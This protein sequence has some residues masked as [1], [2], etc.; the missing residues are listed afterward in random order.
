VLNLKK[1]EEKPNP[2]DTLI[3]KLASEMTDH[4]GYDDEYTKMAENMKVLCEARAV[5]PKADK[6]SADTLAV[7]VGNLVGI[8]AIM[9]HERAHIITT[10][11]LSFIMKPRS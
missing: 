8:I 11:A 1:T 7:V 6:L 4:D 10:K 5:M 9:N 2:V 3:E